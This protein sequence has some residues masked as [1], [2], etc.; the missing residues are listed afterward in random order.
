MKILGINASPWLDVGHDASVALVIDGELK[1]AIEEER[2][3]RKKRAYDLLPLLSIKACLDSQSLELDDID[4][5]VFS[6]DWV[7]V[8]PSKYA[9]YSVKT[10]EILSKFFPKKY[11]DYKKIPQIRYVEHHLAHAASTFRCSGFEKAAILVVDGQGEYCSSSI[12]VGDGNKIKKIW[13]NSIEESI[14]YFYSSIERYIGMRNGDEG[15]LMGLAPYGEPNE[16]IIKKLES[17]KFALNEEELKNRSGQQKA[18]VTLLLKNF[19]ELFGSK[20]NT[21][22]LFNKMTGQFSKIVNFSEYQKSIA[23]SAQKI[24]EK[25][26]LELVE[27]AVQLTGCDRLCLSGGVAL[28]CIANQRIL[29]SGRVK[30]IYVQ[31][32]SNDAGSSIGAALE[33]CAEKGGKNKFRLDNVYLGPEF[34]NEEIENELRKFKIVYTK[35]KDICLKCARL[36]SEGKI[37]GWFQGKME[38][39]PRA[40]GNR[41]VISDPTKKDMWAK[42]NKVKERELW[43]PFAPSILNEK[44]KEFFELNDSF[45][46]MIVGSNVVNSKIG[47]IPAVVHVDGTA[48]PHAVKEEVNSRFYNLIKNFEKITGVPVVM[49]TSFNGKGEPIVC[50]PRDA[51]KAFYSSGLDYLAL[52]DFLIKK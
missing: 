24:I 50:T 16:E 3:T 17:I 32:A 41:S 49:N 48:R 44:K 51:I 38:F 52:G 7:K 40:L 23:S 26:I 14:G 43:R 42:V 10:E 22:T 6:W 8:G 29:E 11:F 9:A 21:N 46:F 33:F 18:V 45:D 34:T 19:D 5:V 13:S 15:K 35:E 25:R 1:F 39:G 36:V 28:N 30:E 37:I 31:P 12:W 27:K 47:V 4:Y 20:D 2:L